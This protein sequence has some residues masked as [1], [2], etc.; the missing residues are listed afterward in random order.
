MTSARCT[1]TDRSPSAAREDGNRTQEKPEEPEQVRLANEILFHPFNYWL[2]DSFLTCCLSAA[3]VMYGKTLTVTQQDDETSSTTT[4][5]LQH[6]H[7]TM[8]RKKAWIS[9]RDLKQTLNT[10]NF[11]PDLSVCVVLFRQLNRQCCFL[12]GQS[13]RML[14]GGLRV[15]GFNRPG[16]L[17]AKLL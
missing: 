10:F 16:E 13:G 8:S 7:G 14:R 9:H 3:T 12:P 11:S 1:S 2:I 4:D 15:T 6:R 17:Q 5:K